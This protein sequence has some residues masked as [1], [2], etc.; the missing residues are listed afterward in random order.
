VSIE[1]VI[2][3]VFSIFKPACEKKRITFMPILKDIPEKL[4]VDG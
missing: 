1:R 2:K 3:E 4:F